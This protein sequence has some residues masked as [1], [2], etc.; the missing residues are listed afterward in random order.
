MFEKMIVAFDGTDTGWDGLLLSMGLAKA[1]GSHVAVV[2]VYDVELAA[3]STEAA[4]ELAEHA[5]AV[6]AGAREGVSQALAISFCAL[7]ASS[8]ARGLHELAEGEQADLIVL[9]SRRLGPH[10]RAALGAVSENVMRAAPCAVAVAPRGYRS[11][12]G[13]VPQR[14]GVGWIPTDEGG[15]ALEVSCRIARATGGAVEV[16]TT[17]SAS[18][19]VDE[20]EARARRAVEGVLTALG[21]EIRVEVHARVAK[22]SDVLVNRSGELDLIVLGSRGYGPPRTMLFGSVSAQVVSQAR[23]PVIILAAGART[24]TE[25]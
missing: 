22:A 19:A 6:L 17:T 7:P 20:L 21:G 8:P 13:F 12:G 15:T 9:G 16:V 1:F 5:D 2:Y 3:S 25:T 24:R 14:I 4:R 18:A 10:T 11:D 23:C